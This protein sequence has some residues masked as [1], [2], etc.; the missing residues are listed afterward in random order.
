MHEAPKTEIPG[1][2]GTGRPVNAIPGIPR[3]G[4][5]R[6]AHEDVARP[7]SGSTRRNDGDLPQR[8]VP[9]LFEPAVE[10]IK[11]TARPRQR[12][13]GVDLAREAGLAPEGNTWAAMDRGLEN[14]ENAELARLIMKSM[15]VTVRGE[16]PG[17]VLVIVRVLDMDEDDD[18]GSEA[19]ELA[20]ECGYDA[21]DGEDE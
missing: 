2:P 16:E 4:D 19:R 6:R 20:R 9:G 14:A 7:G 18:D 8:H 21:F 11:F 3:S 17:D 5:L 1:R 15:D 10:A 12:P 13:L